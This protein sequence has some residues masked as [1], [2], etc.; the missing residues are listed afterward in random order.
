M[1]E[2]AR[3]AGL[4]GVIAKC[5]DSNYESRRSRNW[6]KIKVVGQ[7]EFIICGFTHGERDYFSSLVLGVY[8]KGEL[9]YVGNV[10]TGFNDRNLPVLWR[11]LEKRV[12]PKCPFKSVPPMLRQAT[13]VKPELV[14][15]CKY[16]EW[17]RDGKLRAPVFLGLRTDKSPE[18]V[19]RETPEATPAEERPTPAEL[20]PKGAKEL[21]ITIE[22]R[23]L[24]FS[25]LQKVMFPK[26]KVTKA[27]ILNYYNAISGLI[28]PHL[29][30]RPL[31]LKRYPNGIH[32]EHFFQ[33][34]VEYSEW[35]RTEAIPS[36]HRGAPINYV[37]CNDRA[38]LLYLTNLGCIDKNEPARRARMS[39]LH[40]DRPRSD[41]HVLRQ[42]R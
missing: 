30:D 16:A 26:D 4:E 23:P 6:L 15:E 39:R 31:S 37:I 13:W 38:T 34:N 29:A 35:L 33:K 14:C 40:P 17:T 41:G 9:V 24:K 10:G 32:E 11:E 36:E 42:A 22:G 5:F 3:Q 28:I 25:N 27:D 12:T 1:L 19:V 8:D 2:A 7:Q 18:E 21:A 20:V